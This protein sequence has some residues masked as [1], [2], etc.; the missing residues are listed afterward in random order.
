ME[1]SNISGISE[2]CSEISNFGDAVKT[3]FSSKAETSD[4][5]SKFND[6]TEMVSSLVS[7]LTRFWIFALEY[8]I[9]L[10]NNHY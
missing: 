2:C 4:E 1:V 7:T 9:Y 5:S 10:F 3:V 6:G 8:I